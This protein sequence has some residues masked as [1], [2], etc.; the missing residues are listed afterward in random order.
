MK[1]QN[2]LT[3]LACLVLAS[4]LTN[5]ANDSI[6]DREEAEEKGV[7]IDPIEEIEENMDTEHGWIVVEDV[8]GLIKNLWKGF[9]D[10]FMTK[11][12]SEHK[13]RIDEEMCFGEW[14]TKD[15][16]F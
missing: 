14:M 15:A 8:R 5:A 4:S 12:S 2:L 16:E 13:I 1:S 7:I 6:I 11:A 10:G 9:I 3:L